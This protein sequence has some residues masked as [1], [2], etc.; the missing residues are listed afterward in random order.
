MSVVDHATMEMILHT[1]N[2]VSRI[3][4]TPFY[5][6]LYDYLTYVNI[7]NSTE[8]INQKSMASAS[9]DKGTVV[10]YP[11]ERVTA[12]VE[13]L[14]SNGLPMEAGSLMLLAQGTHEALSHTSSTYAKLF[15]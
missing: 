2:V 8:Q 6:L 3:I 4:A 12:T 14:K 7:D 11:S 13:V 1:K 10:I 5:G 9:P 15:H